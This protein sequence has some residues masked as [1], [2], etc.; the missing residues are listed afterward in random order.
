MAGV[1]GRSGKVT[2]AAQRQARRAAAQAGGMAKAGRSLPSGLP[3][4]KEVL[5]ALPDAAFAVDCWM[6]YKDYLECEL[7]KRKILEAD[8]DVETAAAKRDQERGRLLTVT[9]VRERDERHTSAFRAALLSFPDLLREW[10]P[11]DKI[12]AAQ[13][14]A[15]EWV[16]RQLETVAN[17]VK[18][19]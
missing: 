15:R 1:K 17:Q 13:A 3:S 2:T 18:S 11:A 14:A 10:V 5:K 12:L 19:G 8:I 9:Q 4:G 16:D 6:A 7:R